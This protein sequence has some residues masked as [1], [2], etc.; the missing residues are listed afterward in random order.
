MIVY[1]SIFVMIELYK[2]NYITK[3]LLVLKKKSNLKDVF[4]NEIK[5]WLD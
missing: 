1:T 3:L 4:D 2:K 5:K